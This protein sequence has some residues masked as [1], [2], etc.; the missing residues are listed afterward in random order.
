MYGGDNV[1]ALENLPKDN[2]PSVEP[3]GDLKGE[4]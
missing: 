2:V 3:G 4:R 1:H